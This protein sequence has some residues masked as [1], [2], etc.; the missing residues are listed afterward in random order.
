[1]AKRS[2]TNVDIAQRTAEWLGVQH[3]MQHMDETALA[4]RFKDAI[5]HCEHH[6]YDLNFVGKFALSELPRENGYKVVLTGEGA[7]EIFAGY[8]LYLPDFLREADNSWHGPGS[9]RPEAE[10]QRM[11]AEAEEL[12]ANAYKV[13]G[14]YWTNRG[15]NEA[16]RLLNGITTPAS[17]CAFQFDAFTGWPRRR[18]GRTLR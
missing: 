6:S 7:D 15:D 10:R 9:V 3:H 17:M 14:A 2:L 1:M 16:R 11:C 8:F 18:T 12:T 5:W 4:A 13:I